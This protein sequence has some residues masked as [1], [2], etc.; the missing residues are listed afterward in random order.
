MKKYIIFDLDW[1]LINSNNNIKE[2]IFDYFKINDIENYDKVRYTLDFDKI[3]SIKELLEYVYSGNEENIDKKHDEIYKYLDEKNHKSKFIDWTI[4]KIIELKDRYKLYLSTWSSTK[5]AE[6]ILEI[7]WIKKYFE[8]I[9]WS[10]KIQKS[11]EHLDIF[12]EKSNDPNF[13]QLS[14][15]IW[16]SPKDEYFAKQRNINFIKIWE[17]YKSIS[18]IKNI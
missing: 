12:M 11:E 5:F 8:I 10:E 7:W 1:T 14:I 4:K 2:I 6:E 18:D 15:S 16:D 9:L 13:F 3:S 17:K